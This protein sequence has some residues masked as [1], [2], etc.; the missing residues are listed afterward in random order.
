L[1]SALSNSPS[2]AEPQFDLDYSIHDFE[3]DPYPDSQYLYRRIEEL[4][5]REGT[6]PGGRTL[7]VA[8]GVG[9]IAIEIGKRDT[10]AFGLEPSNEMLGLSRYLFPNA[11]VSLVRGVAES[12]PFAAGAFD[13]VVCQGALDH[14]V[15]PDDFMRE[16]ARVIAPDGRIVI[17]L[18]NYESLSCKLGRGFR[19]LALRFFHRELYAH[20]PYYEIPEDHFHK[21]DL[22]FV[23]SLGGGALRLERCYGISL[24][25]LLRAGTRWSWGKTLAR[26]PR[27]LASST[28]VTLDAFARRTPALADMIVSVWKRER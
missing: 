1:S 7:D 27:P 25:W 12:L 9:K 23:R 13:R 21:G 4:M 10:V 24:L 16:A 5:I 28:L 20:R 11:D 3:A 26:W 14:F 15:A 17:A 19:S 2:S 8:C 22:P 6:I 18:A